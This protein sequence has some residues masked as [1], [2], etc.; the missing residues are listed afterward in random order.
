MRKVRKKKK[1]PQIL[2]EAKYPVCEK[3]FFPAAQHVYRD[4][5]SPYKR[6]CS[7]GCVCTSERLKEKERAKN[8]G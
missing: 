8:E 1:A 3:M 2:A 6:V 5:R 7:W 4:R